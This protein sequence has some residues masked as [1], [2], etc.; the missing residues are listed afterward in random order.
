MQDNHD[1][2]IL[3]DIQEKL[4]TLAEAVAVSNDRL[5]E[6]T[7]AI[8]KRLTGVENRLTGVE[9]NTDRILAIV[10]DLYPLKAVTTDHEDK[11]VDLDTRVSAL[12]MP[13]RA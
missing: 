5:A 3:E 7:A 6:T 1:G 4:I 11:L 12:E 8:E 9:N 10:E 2:V 13:Q